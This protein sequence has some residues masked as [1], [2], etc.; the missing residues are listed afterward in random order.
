MFVYGDIVIITFAIRMYRFAMNK[1]V[2]AVHLLFLTS[3]TSA[4]RL[5][6]HSYI[7]IAG[8]RKME[9]N[10]FCIRLRSLPAVA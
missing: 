5:K 3:R 4:G 9:V 1:T 10:V 7:T 6:R 2:E 8:L